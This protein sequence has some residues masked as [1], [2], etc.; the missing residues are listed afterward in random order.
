MEIEISK[1]SKKKSARG[2]FSQNSNRRHSFDECKE[3]T[4]CIGLLFGTISIPPFFLNFKF[5][6][7]DIEIDRLY[8][9]TKIYDLRRLWKKERVKSEESWEITMI[10]RLEINNSHIRKR[11]DFSRRWREC[12]W[13]CI[14]AKRLMTRPRYMYTAAKRQCKIFRDSLMFCYGSCS[15]AQTLIDRLVDQRRDHPRGER[16]RERGDIRENSRD[17]FATS[18]ENEIE[19]KT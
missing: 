16:G 5:L 7:I 4:F 9:S 18:D 13:P 11:C 15:L 10:G 3:R 6:M 17:L 12:N 14:K 1:D 2:Y 8:F 19:N